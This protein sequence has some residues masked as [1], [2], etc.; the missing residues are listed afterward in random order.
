[1]DPTAFVLENITNNEKERYSQPAEKGMTI[2]FGDVYG[3]EL[4]TK[5]MDYDVANLYP[6]MQIERYFVFMVPSDAEVNGYQITYKPENVS[7]PLANPEAT[8]N[9]QRNQST[10]PNASQSEQP[11]KP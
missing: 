1:L 5:V 11:S 2:A 10:L 3:A 6:R 9:D 8:I 4:K 7:T